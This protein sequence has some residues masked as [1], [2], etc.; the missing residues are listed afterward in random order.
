MRLYHGSDILVT[1]PEI[2][3]GRPYKDFGKGFYLSDNLQQAHNMASQKA[4]LS[5]N[6]VPVVSTYEFRESAMTDGTLDVKCFDTYTE[7]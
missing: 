6:A 5:L 2:E 7:E 4:A 1:N 3:K